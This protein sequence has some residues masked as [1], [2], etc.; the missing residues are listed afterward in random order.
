MRLVQFFE[1]VQP[2]DSMKDTTYYHGTSKIANAKAIL[3]HGIRPGNT[4]GTQRR[5]MQP[6]SGRTYITPDLRYAIIYA[7]GGDMLGSKLPPSMYK[8]EPYGYVFVFNGSQLKNDVLPDEDE[9]GRA[10]EY[11]NMVLNGNLDKLDQFYSQDKLYQRMKQRDKWWLESF[12]HLAKRNL[13]PKQYRDTIE[14]YAAAWAAAGKRLQKRLPEDMLKELI[15]MGVHVA[16]EG[17]IV[18]AECWRIDKRKTHLLNKDG[19]NFFEIAQKVRQ[20]RLPKSKLG[21]SIEDWSGTWVHYTDM[22]QLSVNPKPFHFDPL[23][24]YFF[25]SDFKPNSGWMEKKYKITATI[26]PGAKIMDIGKDTEQYI[27]Q[28]LNVAPKK[29][30]DQYHSVI[31]TDYKASDVVNSVERFK[32]LW[33]VL[34]QSFAIVYP[35]KLASFNKFFRSLGYDAIFDDQNIIHAA[36]VQLLVLNRKIINVISIDDNKPKNAYAIM[37]KMIDDFTKIAE[38]YG[39]VEVTEPKAKKSHYGNRPSLTGWVRIN[40]DWR[41][42]S[43]QFEHERGDK[44]IRAFVYVSSPSLNYGTGEEYHLLANRF[45]GNPPWSDLKRALDKI[46]T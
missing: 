32:I 18:P 41:N 12:L 19:S 22:P 44:Y 3:K 30:V 15:G 21:E 34:S 13:T 7:I 39:D 16:Y 29:V 38:Q 20:I 33:R 42:A 6:V 10:V 40:N 26:K 1:M 45:R 25:P 17:T 27:K 5:Q 43:I 28:I 35:S 23:G 31:E 24:I 37:K 46:F 2:L 9:I 14:G 8:D 4:S 11:A 36:E